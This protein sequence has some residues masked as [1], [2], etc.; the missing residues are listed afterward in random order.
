MRYNQH[1]ESQEELDKT[2]TYL[3][4]T[5]VPSR[6]K[7]LKRTSIYKYTGVVYDKDLT[8]DCYY[9]RFI[10]DVIQQLC[11]ENNVAY[12]FNMDSLADVM[13]FVGTDIKVKYIR[14]GIYSITKGGSRN[15][16]N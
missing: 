12:I 10:N 7:R 15:D 4:Q 2:V 14:N 16:T 6:E 9:V 5:I 3:K 13:R 1:P 8:S 11:K